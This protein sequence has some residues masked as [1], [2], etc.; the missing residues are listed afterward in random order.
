MT[1]MRSRHCPVCG[2]SDDS[3]VYAAANISPEKFSTYSYA[4]RKLPEYMHHRLLECPRCDLVYASP[5]PVVDTLAEAYRDAAFDSQ[6]EGRC[7][8]Q[9]YARY[10]RFIKPRLGTFSG[11]LDIGA[12]DGSFL[13]ELLRAGF[14]DVAGIE[15]SRAPIEAARADI[16]PLIRQQMF[17]PKSVPAAT[18]SLVTC[19][20]TIEHVDDPLELC[21]GAWRGLRAGG[22]IFLIGHDR[23]ALSAKILGRRS[24]IFDIE[25]LQ[26]F[27]RRSFRELLERA[28]FVDISIRAVVN[29]YPLSYWLRLLPLPAAAKR[30]GL[31]LLSR[32]GLGRLMVAIPA[33]NLAVYAFKP[34]D[35]R[36]T[37]SADR[38]PCSV[39][40]TA[41]V[42]AA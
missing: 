33:G 40:G 39:P 6:A 4:S 1:A 24:P 23:R 5:I 25:H 38:A 31:A 17:D 37:N 30:R 11:A 27:S 8:G 35:G 7:A 18:L 19:F 2:S 12:G 15:P 26:L 29:R 16:R 13:E 41:G 21:R 34:S 14:T 28:G 10:L 20:Q 42:A 3:H 22:S 32:T 9:T 36:P